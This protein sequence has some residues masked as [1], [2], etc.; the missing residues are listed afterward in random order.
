LLMIYFFLPKPYNKI[1]EKAR[2]IKTLEH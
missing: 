2:D 1:G